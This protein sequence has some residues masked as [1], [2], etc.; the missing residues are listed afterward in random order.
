MLWLVSSIGV[1]I[2]LLLTPLTSFTTFSSSYLH[3]HQ[4]SHTTPVIVIATI[5][6][7]LALFQVRSMREGVTCIDHVILL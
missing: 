2:V 5:S 4:A 3:I 6:T 7:L 1:H